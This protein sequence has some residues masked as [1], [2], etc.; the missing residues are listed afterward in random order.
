M[1]QYPSKYDEHHLKLV[2]NEAAGLAKYAGST[3]DNAGRVR[4]GNT[5]EGE[6]VISSEKLEQIE[7]Y[8]RETVTSI[9]GYK[10]YEELRNGINKELNR[11]FV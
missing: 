5:N 10:T 7:E 2:R 8:W 9:T 6:K 11:E 3:T 4:N 1:K